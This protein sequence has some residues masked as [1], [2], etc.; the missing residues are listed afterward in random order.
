MIVIKQVF[1]VTHTVPYFYNNNSN[2]LSLHSICCQVISNSC[3]L[4][5]RQKGETTFPRLQSKPQVKFLIY[6]RVCIRNASFAVIQHPK[7]TRYQKQFLKRLKDLLLKIVVISAEHKNWK[8]VVLTDVQ[9]ASLLGKVTTPLN[10]TKQTNPLV[11]HNSARRAC[12]FSGQLRL[13]LNCGVD[14][15]HVEINNTEP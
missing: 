8:K 4:R 7:E 10:K 13:L 1:V 5:G 15:S 14:S 3:P 12:K 11:L 9:S 6:L 2:F